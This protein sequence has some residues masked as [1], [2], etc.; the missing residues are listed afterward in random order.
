MD[1]GIHGLWKRWSH[2]FARWSRFLQYDYYTYVICIPVCYITHERFIWSSHLA[3]LPDLVEEED[4]TRANSTIQGITSISSIV[5]P[6]SGGVIY[7]L[8]GIQA[9][10]LLNGISFVVSGISELFIQYEQVTKKIEKLHEVST[11]LKEGFFF[12][13]EHKGLLTLLGFALVLN[14][15]MGPFVFV[16]VPYVLRT[17]IGFSSE[18]YGLIQTSFVT[19]ILIGNVVIG[20]LLAKKR[21]KP[22]LCNGLLLQIGFTFVFVGLLFP[23][24]LSY[25]GYASW[26]L[27]CLLFGTFM[28][29]L[30]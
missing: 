14:F 18:Q 19:G 24:V 6:V 15:L 28:V 27:F 8:G 21:I 17:V 2:P 23:H 7:G 4:L 25:F 30:P 22:M 10:F 5:G 9:A 1:H 3:M 16:L 11:D 13:K 12:I 20:T 26:T 29:I